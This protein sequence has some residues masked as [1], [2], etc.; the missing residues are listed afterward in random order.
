MDAGAAFEWVL[1]L[2]ILFVTWTF[3]SDLRVEAEN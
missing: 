2:G 3:A 1:I